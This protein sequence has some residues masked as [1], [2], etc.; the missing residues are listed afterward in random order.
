VNAAATQLRDEI[1]ATARVAALRPIALT[2]AQL[3]AALYAAELPLWTERRGDGC[4]LE[5]SAVPARTA[6]RY[7]TLGQ[8]CLA[9]TFDAVTDHPRVVRLL[10]ALDHVLAEAGHRGELDRT[11]TRDVVEAARPGVVI[12][13][14]GI[15]V[16]GTTA[17]A[18]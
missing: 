17:V 14:V 12:Y 6:R 16:L 4:P 3:D 10:L 9:V 2:P 7:P 15:T 13:L 5:V 11:L 18:S 1:R 8:T